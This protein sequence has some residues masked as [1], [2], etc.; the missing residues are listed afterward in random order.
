MRKNR[1]LMCGIA[2]GRRPKRWAYLLMLLFFCGIACADFDARQEVIKLM[3]NAGMKKL[4]EAPVTITESAFGVLSIADEGI[5]AIQHELLTPEVSAEPN[6]V[7]V[8]GIAIV[9]SA[10]K[11]VVITHG[12]LDKGEKDWP[13]KMAEAINERVDPNEWVCA[14]YDWRGGSV[15]FTSVQAAQY[16]RDIAGPRLAAAL[17]KLDRPFKHVH[18]IGHS[19]G[20]W[21]IQ[22]AA[23]QLAHKYPDARFHLTFLDAYVPEEWDAEELGWIFEDPDRQKNQ[24]W[25]EQYYTRD[26]TW[27]V[28]EY[29]LKQAHNVDISALDPLI[30]EHEFPYRWYMATITGRY[31]RWDEKKEPVIT[32]SGDIDYGFAR[33]LESGTDNWTQSPKLPMHNKAVTIKAKD[34]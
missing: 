34:K 1:W 25:A 8:P 14:S 22:S 23:G 11:L 13:S 33:A 30:V 10:D 24:C 27:K 3:E 15:V 31:D 7:I 26:I 4:L 2:S 20:S 21:V 19:A 16:A 17:L 6:V 9:P 29:N 18:L 28:T 5:F 32:C 12:W